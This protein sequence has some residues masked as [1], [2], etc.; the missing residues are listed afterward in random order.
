MPVFVDVDIPTYNIDVSRI[1]AAIGPK[2]R[3]I[4]L[5]HTLG[6]PFDLD[7]IVRDREGSTTCG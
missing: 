7:A 5:A 1:E 6:N 3:A 4:M 2:T